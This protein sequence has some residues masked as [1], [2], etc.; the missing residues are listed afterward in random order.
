[1][2]TSFFDF[3]EINNL[4]PTLSKTKLREAV[5]EK[6]GNEK[7]KGVKVKEICDYMKKCDSVNITEK[8]T[9]KFERI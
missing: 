6:M 5:S 2:L 7:G 9:L 1:M 3:D 8:E 4:R